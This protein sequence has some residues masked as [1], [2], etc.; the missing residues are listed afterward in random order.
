[1]KIKTY[2]IYFVADDGGGTGTGGASE[3]NVEA[4]PVS[5]PGAAGMDFQQLAKGLINGS[6]DENH[7]G[8]KPVPETKSVIKAEPK[9]ETKVELKTEPKKNFE[10]PKSLIKK[11]EPKIDEPSEIDKI[12][13]PETKDDKVKNS[14]H[15][16]REIAKSN[17]QRAKAAELRLKEIEGKVSGSEE[18][19]SKLAELEKQNK[20]FSEIVS[21][22]RIEAHPAFKA[23]YIDGRKELIDRAK[24]LIEESDGDPKIVETALNLHGKPRVEA[25]REFSGLLDSYQA[26][27]LG[28][29]IDELDA[30]DT[31]AS[32]K[33]A[34]S[35]KSWEEYQQQDQEQQFSQKEQFT[36]RS[37]KAFDGSLDQLRAEYEVLNK[38]DGEDS[39]WWNDQVADIETKAREFYTGNK[40][41][42][43]SA[44]VAIMAQTAPVYRNLFLSQ[45]EANEVISKELAEAKKELEAIN[46]KTP[47]LR[48]GGESKSAPKDD[49]ITAYRKAM[50]N[51]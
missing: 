31:E 26:G 10:I 8:E 24:A 14:F 42:G 28:R 11:E 32:S 1:M 34:D 29:V 25:L 13:A 18:L 41:V 9:V 15:S 35:Q 50:G 49:F 5:V 19:Q 2:S 44:E 7:I 39:K 36:K 48:G 45:R 43:K 47:N 46:K 23:K 51:E 37:L 38:A 30:L 6:I 33:I 27:R 40:D 4:E 12:V 20:E 21:R 3:G 16:L 22:S 17:E